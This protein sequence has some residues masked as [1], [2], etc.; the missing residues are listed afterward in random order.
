MSWANQRKLG[1]RKGRERERELPIQIQ[2]YHSWTWAQE[3][4]QTGSKFEH[5]PD[6]S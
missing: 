2:A 6:L 3:L 1:G 5:E 4:N